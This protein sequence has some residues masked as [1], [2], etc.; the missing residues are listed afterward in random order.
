MERFIAIDNV[1]AWPNLTALPDGTIAAAIFNQPCHGLWEGDVEWWASNDGGRSWDRRAAVTTHD[2][3]TNRMNVAS[4]LNAAGEPIVLVSG[5]SHRPP[6]GTGRA[7]H[8]PPAQPL[9]PWICRSGDGGRTWD[10]LGEIRSPETPAQP[11]IP[12]GDIVRLSDD[13]LGVCLYRARGAEPHCLFYASEDD[14]LSWQPRGV[15]GPGINETT[16][17]VL[18]DGTLVA[19]ARTL[20][21]QHLV[22]HQSSDCGATWRSDRPISSGSQHPAHLLPLADGRLLLAYGD[23]RDGHHGI[24]VRLA[25]ERGRWSDPQRLV[26][27]DPG[28]L[29][30]P[31]TAQN[32]DASLV[33]AWYSAGIAAHTRYH[34][35]VAVWRTDELF[36]S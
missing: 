23:R 13:C 21:D 1:C 12:F 6:A 15:I 7:D 18:A 34:M 2:P 9:A 17:A 5:W 33:T 16:P 3:G 14:G 8:K 35:G 30:Y 20:G 11:V 29:G 25:D 26:D 4:G 28:D 36:G 19:C 32:P 22:L 27:L 31:A 24:D 10:R